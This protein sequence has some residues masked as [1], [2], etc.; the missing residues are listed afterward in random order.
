LHVLADLAANR[1]VLELAIAT[2]R[3]ALPLAAR[4]LSVHGIDVSEAMMGRLHQKPGGG[5]R[6]KS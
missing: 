3:M 4:G 2:G 6:P 5:E 1:K